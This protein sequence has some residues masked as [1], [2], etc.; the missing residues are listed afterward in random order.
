MKFSSLEEMIAHIEKAQSTATKNMGV[1][2]VEIMKEE[3]QQQVYGSYSPRD[4]NRTMQ[5]LNSPQITNSGNNYV[6]VAF[7][8]MG[9]WKSQGYGMSSYSGGGSPFFP[10]Y[11]LEHGGVWGRGTTNI[12]DESVSR[13]ETEIPKCYRDTM[14]SMGIPIR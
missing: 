13:I 6:S 12:M 10:M 14:S 4:Y 1:E 2:M 8:M 9:D 5:L 7:M 11:G 3:V